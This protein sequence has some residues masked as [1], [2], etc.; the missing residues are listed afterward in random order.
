MFLPSPASCPQREQSHKSSDRTPKSE[1]SESRFRHFRHSLL[2][3]ASTT[4][5]KWHDQSGRR[6][7]TRTCSRVSP[8][9][10]T[11]I[12]SAD[13]RTAMDFIRKIFARGD[14][15]AAP[16][17]QPLVADRKPSSETTAAPAVQPDDKPGTWSTESLDSRRVDVFRPGGTAAGTVLFLHGHGR[18][19]LNENETFTDLLNEFRLQM[20]CPDGGQSWWSHKICRQFSE[21]L[22]AQDWLLQTVVPWID[23]QFQTPGPVALCGVSM[24]GQGALQLAYRHARQF[25]VVAAIAPAVDFHQL[26]GQGLPLDSMYESA[27]DARQDT[28][29]LNLHPLAWPRRQWFCCDPTDTDWFDGCSRLSMKLSSSGIPHEYDL[30]TSGGGHS[31]DYFNRMARGALSHIATS[32]RDF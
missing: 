3:Q 16:P 31:W 1:L 13:K 29:V 7:N 25:P 20:I 10:R 28:V 11:G 18:V 15:P 17:V 23:E 26:Y 2:T 9:C 6:H 19:F 12:Y 22:S 21:T 5:R 24:G 27:E 4:R 32:L 30:T 14:A 8:D